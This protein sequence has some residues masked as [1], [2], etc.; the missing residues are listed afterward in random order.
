MLKYTSAVV[1]VLEKIAKQAK[2]KNDCLTKKV[3][4][5]ELTS[6][7]CTPHMSICIM[8]GSRR[9]KGDWGSGPPSLKNHKNTGFLSNTGQDPLKNHKA[10]KQAFNVG[11]SSAR[12]QNTF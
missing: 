11:P 10:T 7:H 3:L 9:D 2:H 5:K 4:M 1:M 6:E 12:R 8:G